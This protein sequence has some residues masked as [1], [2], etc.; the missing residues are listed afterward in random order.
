MSNLNSIDFP[1]P[2]YLFK[3]MKFYRK[4]PLSTLRPNQ[5][6]GFKKEIERQSILNHYQKEYTDKIIFE[7]KHPSKLKAYYLFKIIHSQFV[8]DLTTY[9]L[10][11][12]KLGLQVKPLMAE[13]LKRCHINE[14]EYSLERAY[15]NWQR[16]ENKK[17]GA[18]EILGFKSIPNEPNHPTK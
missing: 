17:T 2:S 4:Y 12:N 9:A 3:W 8:N 15:K 18:Y 13:F 1:V 6:L 14:N 7:M 11:A 5:D 10:A 16:L